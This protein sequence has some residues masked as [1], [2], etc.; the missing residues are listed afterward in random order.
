MRRP[1]TSAEARE[2]GITRSAIRWGIRTG[3]YQQ[4]A[5]G[6]FIKGS[7]PPTP[8]ELAMASVM[9][10]RGVA[11]FSLAGI[12]YGLDGI[13]LCEPFRANRKAVM[14][15]G[16]RCADA[17]ETLIDLAR[18][19]DDLK[20]EQAFESAL[21]KKLVSFAD[22]NHVCNKRVRRVL[23]LRGDVPPTGSIL[24]TYMTQLIRRAPELPAPE[25]QVEVFHPSGTFAGRPDLVWRDPGL[26]VE[27]D[28]RQ[29][30][31]QRVYD[32]RRET[33]VVVATG[34]LP[35][36]FTWY[37]VVHLPNTTLRRLVDLFELASS[38]RDPL[39]IGEITTTRGSY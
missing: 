1:F 24:E 23:E 20:W 27:L 19:L 3:R 5:R 25:R 2:R 33:S 4:L 7:E 22:F 32:A 26:F 11:A 21:R 15:D 13:E 38:G 16:Y 30:A 6:V 17:R 39:E 37:E 31:T 9:A 35:A 36:R 28:G 29:H 8:V 10:A 14:V 34:W 12:L 18:V